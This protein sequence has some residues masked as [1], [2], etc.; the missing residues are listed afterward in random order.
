MLALLATAWV[1]RIGACATTC[2]PWISFGDTSYSNRLL[3]WL[4]NLKKYRCARK[5]ENDSRSVYVSRIHPRSLRPGAPR[6][7]EDTRLTLLSD[8]GDPP[9]HALPTVLAV[10]YSTKLGMQYVFKSP[11]PTIEF[12]SSGCSLRSSFFFLKMTKRI[13]ASDSCR[14]LTRFK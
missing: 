12:E 8:D 13:I 9:M 10:F 3:R 7:Q 6:G 4:L 2:V 1:R 14:N 11:V 5:L